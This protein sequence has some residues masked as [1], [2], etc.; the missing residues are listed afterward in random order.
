MSVEYVI[1]ELET[2]TEWLDAF[3]VIKQLRPHLTKQSYVNL[4]KAS[5]TQGYRLIALK[6]EGTVVAVIGFIPMT[7]LYYGHFIWVCDLVTDSQHR[8]KGFGELLLNYVEKD[9]KNNDFSC[10]AL[11]SGIQREDAH[12]FYENKQRYNRVSYVFKKEL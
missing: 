12:R 11:S 9:A 1:E 7:T 2:E 8:S 10:I 3:F 5:K 6:I 4:T